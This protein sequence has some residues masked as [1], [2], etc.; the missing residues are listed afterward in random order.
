MAAKADHAHRPPGRAAGASHPTFVVAIAP[1]A[2]PL[3]GRFQTLAEARAAARWLRRREPRVRV[4]EAV[5]Y[6]RDVSEC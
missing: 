4:F 6:F 3:S 1:T 2:P 5:T